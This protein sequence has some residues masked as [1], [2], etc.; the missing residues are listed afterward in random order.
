MYVSDILQ[1][2]RRVRDYCEVASR[3]APTCSDVELALMDVGEATYVCIYM[4]LR[5]GKCV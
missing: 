1:V 2:G 3:T 4:Y 5:V